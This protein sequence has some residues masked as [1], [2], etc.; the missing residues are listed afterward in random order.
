MTQRVL[1]SLIGRSEDWL[2]KVERNERDLRRLDVVS[3]LASALRVSVGDLLGNPVLMETDR[4]KEDDVP[5]VR[6]ALMSHRRLS[7]DPLRSTDALSSRP[8]TSRQARRTW[9]GRLLRVRP[10]PS[11]G[12]P[13][14][15]LVACRPWLSTS[16]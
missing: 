8:I 3:E 4:A 2:G 15:V 9:M 10:D 14:A 13:R 16:A 12:V 6:D 5:A 1:A 11:A 7:P